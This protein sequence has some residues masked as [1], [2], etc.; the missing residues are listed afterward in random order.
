MGK[1]AGELARQSASSK[2]KKTLKNFVKAGDNGLAKISDFW[3]DY[4][5][6]FVTIS[7]DRKL[8]IQSLDPGAFF[9]VLD[10][11]FLN[12]LIE[13]GADVKDES[14]MQRVI[15]S[16][17]DEERIKAYEDNVRKIICMG[18]VSV[19]FV[20]KPPS[21]CDSDREVSVDRLSPVDQMT[22]YNAIRALSMPEE[23][24]ETANSFRSEGK[25]EKAGTAADTPDSEGIRSETVGDT[26]S[27]N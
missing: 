11:P 1:N 13:R 16:L 17:T 15:D 24:A 26:V 12:L 27:K 14:S 9:L 23:D 8:E 6:G 2:V 7:K 25:G 19:R 18:V 22:I 3:T 5:T 4:E 20:N 21:R 10:T